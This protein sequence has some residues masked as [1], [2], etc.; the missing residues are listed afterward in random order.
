M[1]L[2]TEADPR[3]RYNLRV[4]PRLAFAI[5]AAYKAGRSTLAHYQTG[6]RVDTKA[7][8]TPVTE[9]DRNAERLI[10]RLV[11]S[12]YP[13]E[14]MLGEEEGGD[15]TRPDRWIIDPID[16]TKSFV[17]GVPLYSTLLSYEVDF[18]PVLGV[19]FFPALNEMLYAEVGGGAFFNGAPA[20]VS[21]KSE[22][23]GGIVCCGGLKSMARYGRSPGFEKISEKA[24]ATRTWCDAYGHALVATGRVEGMVDPIVTRWD[25]SAVQ[26]VVQEAGG[27]FTNFS[28]GPVLVQSNELEAVSSNGLIHEEL[29]AAFQS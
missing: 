28:N 22:V 7:D 16:G 27:R 10:R 11:D 5:D 1:R 9:A 29:L 23:T 2:S 25:L 18:Q 17:A 4:S 6:V 20:R 13:G 24:L 21:R 19:V 3:R 8:E 15:H 26:V 12:T 14:P